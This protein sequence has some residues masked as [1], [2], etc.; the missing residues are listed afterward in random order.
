MRSDCYWLGLPTDLIIEQVLIRIVNACGGLTRGT[1]ISE[2]QRNVRL[3]SLPS[4]A[5]VNEAMQEFSVVRYETSEQPKE[6]S[7]E[8]PSRDVDDTMDILGYFMERNSFSSDI[9]LDSKA[10]GMTAES[11]VNVDKSEEVS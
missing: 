6:V 1:G 3:L 5:H 10:S 7:K 8:R 4:D 11:S 9:V 2:T